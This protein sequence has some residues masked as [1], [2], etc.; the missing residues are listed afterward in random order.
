MENAARFEG[1]SRSGRSR[2]LILWIA[3]AVLVAVWALLVRLTGNAT[4][5]W[6]SI[7]LPVLF[8]GAV[9]LLCLGVLGEY[10]GRIYDEVKR[11]PLYR[12]AGEEP[13]H[14]AACGR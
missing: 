8:L 1:R 7:A 6:T 14:C 11:R 13:E 9:Q 4:P 5:G 3:L 12:V 10:V 2:G